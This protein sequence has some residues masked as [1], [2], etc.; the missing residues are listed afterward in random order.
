MYTQ[1][2]V[3]CLLLFVAAAASARADEPLRWK[4]RAGDKLNYSIVQDMNISG[5][6]GAAGDLANESH[7][8]LDVTWEVASV[9]DAGEATIRLRFDRIRTKMTLPMGGLEYDSAAAG[10]A[11]GMAAINAPFYQA[12]IKAPVEFTLAAN[13]RVASANLPSE[14]QAALKRMPTAAKFGDLTNPETFQAT[15]LPGFPLLPTEDSLE[16]GHTWSVR[17]TTELPDAG[18][19]TIETSFRY[20]GAKQVGDPSMAVIRPTR[21]ISFARDEVTERTVKE[22]SSVGEI[23]FDRA[24]GRLFGSAFNHNVTIAVELAAGSAEQKIEQTV[25]VKL[26]PPGE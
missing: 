20:E 5:V 21:T 9:S 13:G 26:A 7:Q 6:G 14:V 18:E 15:F 2:R 22:Q 8:Q 16:P 19:Q 4:L 10:P 24:A 17:S 25:Q 1:S 12:L 23:Q 3:F 11:L